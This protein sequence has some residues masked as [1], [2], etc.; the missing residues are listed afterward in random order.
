MTL[1]P[2]I[3]P[4]EQPRKRLIK[5][6]V[7]TN[8]HYGKHPKD[9]SIQELIS[10]GC[11]LV[12]K[13]SGPS[14]HQVTA[15][16][17]DIFH[18]EKAGHGGTLDP[19][20]TGVLPIALQEGAKAMQ[21][22]LSSGK[23]Y[24]CIMKLHKDVDE[25]KVRKVCQSFVGSVTQKPP[26]RSAVKRV[27]RQRSIYYLDVLEI[28][29]RNVLFRVGCEAGT[30]IRTLCVAIGKKVGTGAHMD[31]LRR[32]KVGLIHEQD[33]STLQEIK[34]AYIIWKE[35]EDST[36]LK[37]VLHPIERLL[38][39]IPKIIIRDSAI[40]ALCHGADLAIPGVVEIDTGITKGDHVAVLSLK[41][42]GVA[43]GT[44]LLSTEEIIAKDTGKCMTL[45][46]VIMKKGT[47]PSTW[48]KG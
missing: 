37:L 16:T 48:K 25:K 7:Q 43:I 12:D 5:A 46:R 11:V 45:D 14:S 31:A 19:K 38:E 4:S 1:T 26:V 36:Q 40:D 20:V 33:L 24:V 30:Y 39:H 3:L 47:Y 27:K 9:R 29:D 8:P 23:E 15:W 13:P 34:D 2:P 42:E 41:N 22:L 18:I 10:T 21:V 28:K 32:T 44:A 17:R 6:Q 35:E